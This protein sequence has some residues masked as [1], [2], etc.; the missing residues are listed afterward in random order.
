MDAKQ[1]AEDGGGDE[2][3]AGSS[4]GEAARPRQHGGDPIAKIT[5]TNIASLSLATNSLAG[6]RN[7]QNF[8]RRL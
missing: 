6:S 1:E 7:G 3:G 5:V 2:A 4:S 8:L